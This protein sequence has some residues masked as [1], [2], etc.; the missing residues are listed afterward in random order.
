M[1]IGNN[2]AYEQFEKWVN[3]IDPPLCII[4]GPSGIGKTYGV[5]KCLKDNGINITYLSDINEKNNIKISND[6]CAQFN[7]FNKKKIIIVD[8]PLTDV[9]DQIELLSNGNN[10][11]IIICN[12]L[13]LKK[14]EKLKIKFLFIE[15]FISQNSDILLFLREKYPAISLKILL[16]IVENCN[17][18]ISIA[19]TNT[20]ISFNNGNTVKK[21]N[22]EKDIDA[23]IKNIFKY[24][25][26]DVFVIERILNDNQ[27]LNPLYIHE[28]MLDALKSRKATNK[29]KNAYYLKILKNLS[30]WSIFANNYPGSLL[31]LSYVIIE[32]YKIKLKEED[33]TK[34]EFSKMFSNLSIQK[35]NALSMR[36]TTF[37]WHNIGV[38]HK[39][40]VDKIKTDI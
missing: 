18:R 40:F 34:V 4:Y 9:F 36:V 37:P 30:I 16:P 8:D 12:E 19:I 6:I 5:M 39:K 31:M 7:N 1:F 24:S 3:N 23:N 14:L 32:M 29:I 20:E 15:L 11:S 38:Y 35:K 13:N 21:E 33:K 25:I 27:W 28:N 2:L 22:I 10:N 17:G 26:L